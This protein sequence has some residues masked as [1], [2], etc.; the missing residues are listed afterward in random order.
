VVD[1]SEAVLRDAIEA[2]F[3]AYREF[4]GRADRI[5]E[6][7]G[8]GRLHHRIL[9]FVGRNPGVSMKGLLTILA[10]SK[11]AINAPLRKLMEMQLVAQTAAT[12]DRRVKRLRLTAAGAELEAELSGV[13]M[14]HIAAAFSAAGTDARAGW[15]AVMVR[16]AD[17][18]NQPK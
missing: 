5:L 17:P 2:L 10:V 15:A 4:T 6:G 14:R 11:Q 9:Y 13:Q 16:L 7:R 18:S 12:E 1:Q 8:L 3:F